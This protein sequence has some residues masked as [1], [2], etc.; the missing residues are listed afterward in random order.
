MVKTK[1]LSSAIHAFWER[2]GRQRII[3]TYLMPL[4]F[5]CAMLVT[6]TADAQI[7]VDGNPA[8]WPAGVYSNPA[9]V[10]KTFVADLYNTAGDDV[11]TGGGSKDISPISL[12][13]WELQAANDKTDI[14][15]AG[16]A[17][18]GNKL[19]FFGDHYSN[20]G[21]ASIGLWILK[22]EVNK[23]P[24]V[25]GLGS[26][27]GSHAD[28]DLLITADLPGG[29]RHVYKWLTG[30]LVEVTL[31]TAAANVV[32]NS[33]LYPAPWPFTP[34]SGAVNTY[35]TSSFFEGFV[36]LDSLGVSVDFCFT[37]FFLSTRTSQSTSA[38]L[39]DLCRGQFATRPVVTVTNDTVCAGTAAEF[40]ASTTG[41]LPPITY[42]WNSAPYAADS[43]YTINPATVDTFVT[44]VAQGSNG[45]LS[46]PDTAYL[47]IKPTATVDTI[48]NFVYCNGAAGSAVTF[49][50]TPGGAT[51]SWS[52]SANVGFGTS[53]T[54]SIG[55]YTATNGGTTPVVA[56]VS[57][58]ATRNSC[59][60]PTRTFMVTVN[61]TPTLNTVSSFAV[62]RGALA[63]AVHFVGG[64][65]GVTNFSWTSSIDI[66][67]GLSGADSIGAFTAINGGLVAL[68]TTVTVT[69]SAA[70][71]PGAPVQFAVTV[72]PSAAVN[73]HGDS[74]YCNGASAGAL[75]FTS[76]VAGTTFTWTASANVGFGASGSG[77]IPGYTATNTTTATIVSTVIVTP[78]AAGCPGVA[79]TFLITVNPT[80]TVG[81]HGEATY[82]N[83]DSASAITFTGGVAGTTFTWTSTINVGFGNAGT[84]NIPAYIA[85]NIGTVKL[86]TSVV[87][88]P[89]A[90]GCTGT[91]DT[92]LV[93]ALPTP[94][95]FAHGDSTYC[96]G[97]SAGAIV[98]AGGGIP[99]ATTFNW[100]SSA[101]VGFGTS[102]VG[103][104]PAYT[105]LNAGLV[106]IVAT[107]I[108]TPTGAG[109]TGV[110][111]TFLITVNPT[112]TVGA[113]GEATYCNGDS[114]SAIAFTGGVAG[115]TF[116]WTSTINVGFGNAGT[117]DIP[118]YIATNIGT[119]KLVTSVV[120][121]PSANGCT[122]TPD[123][124]L[125]TALPT[126][127]VFAHGDST[128]CNGASAGAIVFAGGGIPGATT[129]NW[130]SSANVGFGTSG[131]GDIPAYTALNAGLVPIVATVI[132]TPT[133]AG[134]TGVADTFL[135]TV[136][137]NPSIDPVS[138]RVHCNGDAATG[139]TFSGVPPGI[140]FT[141]VSSI[142][143]G[144]GTSGSGSIGA[145]TATNTGTTPVV[146][147]VTVTPSASSC[148]GGTATF[149]VTVNPT[150]NVA[151]HGDS[152]Y[153]N[154]AS[155][156]ALNFTGGVAGTAF[157]WSGTIDV[158][159]GTAGTGN[160]P[161]YIAT[162]VG[163]VKLI[164]S[165]VVTPSAAGCTGIA[166]TFTVTVL[167][168][169]T[170][171]AHG[172][173]TY[174]NGA[175][176]GAIIFAGGGIPGATT[177][178][179]TSSVN[180]GFGTSGT[181][182]IS[183]YTA[184]NAGLV[185]VV[186]T[187][188]VT[189]TGAGC[190]GVADTFLITVNPT[191]N[192][193]AHGDS[194]YCA[195]A[196]APGLNFTG[197]IGG[198]TFT[199]T[200][201]AN[202]GFGIAGSGNIPAYTALNAGL[203]P[204]VATVIVTPTANG[205]AGTPDTFL[206]TVNPNPS[207]DPVSSRVHCNGD[208]ATGITFSGVPPG[209]TFTWVSSINVG[210]GTSGSGSI[211]AYTAT[212][213][214]TTPVVATV[215]VTPSVTSCGGGVITFMVT[216]NPTPNVA[217]HGDSTYCN[218]ASAGALNFTGG[219]AGTAFTWSGTIDVGFGTAGTG[220]IPA[221]IA[222][223]IGTVKLITSVVVTPSAAGCT[224][225]AD[226]FT[227]TVLPTPT[228]F[229][230]GDST[231]CNGA[232][233]G[234]IIF[235]GGGIPGATT[236][237]WTSSV[238]V[239]FG[240]SGT[241]DISAYTA[242]NA[243][244]VPVVA[245]VIVTPTGAGCTGVADTFLITVNPTPTVAAHGD[246]TYCSSALA[247]GLN[248]TGGIAGTTFTWTSTANVGFGI[249][250]SGNIP[251]YTALNAGLVP[252]VATVIVTP[253]A[254]GC[255]GTPDTFLI[256]VNPNPSIDP[257]SNRVHCNGDAATG[258]TFSG[259]PPGITFTWVS[260]INVGFG[261]SG[262]GS[263]GAYTATNTGTTPVVAT[264]SVT[265]SVTSCGGGVI[266][267]MVTVNP[268]PN[269]AAHGD[270]T[271]CKGILAPGLNFTGAVAGTTFSWT[272]SANVGFGT[273]GAGNIPA[274]TTLNP[275]STN[276]VATVIVTPSKYGCTGAKDTFLITIRPRPTVPY[277]GNVTL[278]SKAPGGPINI[279]GGDVV[280]TYTWIGT[281]NVGFGTSGTGNIGAFTA[282]NNP[283]PGNI[284]DTV[285][286]SVTS[287]AGCPGD[288]RKFT[289]TILPK[290]VVVAR[291]TTLCAGN[292]LNLIPMGTPAGGTWSGPGVS[293]TTFTMGTPGTYKIYYN[294]SNG[295]GCSGY[296]SAYICVTECCVVYG[297]YT[298]GIW[299][300]CNITLCDGKT[301][302]SGRKTPVQL[303]NYLLSS[304]QIT[305]G[306]AGRSVIIPTYAAA[307]V[308]AV[309]PGSY[310]PSKLTYA[311]NV[312]IS[313]AA[314]SIF[315]VNYLSGGKLKNSL[316]GEQ[317]AMKLNVRMTPGLVN[318]PIVYTAGGDSYFQT[319]QAN[320]VCCKFTCGNTCPLCFCIKKSVAK[321]LTKG[322]T[323]AAN[324]NSLVNLADDLLGGV[325]TPGAT[326]GGYVVPSYADV[327][328]A[329]G[330]VSSAFNYFRT[331]NGAYGCSAAKGAIASGN[332]TQDPI[333]IESMTRI[334]PN[335]TTGVFT[336]EVPALEKD[337]HVTVLD[338]NGRSVMSATVSA[339]PYE[340]KVQLDMPDVSRGM[341]FIRIETNGKI[342]AKKLMLE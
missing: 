285:T 283:G 254:N 243:G 182:D 147:T 258:I 23:L 266:T 14:E 35:P 116:T 340:Q 62:C 89:S 288:T 171:F 175:S 115:T 226:T 33:T 177:F 80:P 12:W 111:D 81:A 32:V 303:I 253:T 336:I 56:T 43:T 21:S 17:L 91:P 313:N 102:G 47:V 265:P 103:D 3:R 271:Y 25:A 144:F 142:N 232:S 196:L 37:E 268:T 325:L 94:T 202:V 318:F 264:V 238:N 20:A 69:P 293:G 82:C 90:N 220:N 338:M 74:V 185:P 122:G 222:T 78:S 284:V 57:V 106:P 154:G 305:V 128:Y 183:A 170:V 295:S 9:V 308:N 163:T 186:A 261:T 6:R 280:N 104:I 112:P 256:T 291:D 98:F 230:H 127:T 42:S 282:I 164:T 67:F 152:T 131:V 300:S 165:V 187:V 321:Y 145:Y 55:T 339:N 190:T 292:S 217:V 200:S 39:E 247:P 193:A 31:S 79:D 132:V 249:A 205:C 141:W 198:T 180:V 234:A 64:L 204:V 269:V 63:N 1:L 211:G 150:P 77:N 298:Q 324:L 302:C 11:F 30:G 113:H 84:G 209:I 126:P 4:L 92:F 93:T 223:N 192:V 38:V 248:F 29:N 166:D 146:A 194:T 172:D 139:I 119:V 276:F 15:N 73:P 18:I 179:W 335:P 262:S 176:A 71:C 224:G 105:A 326:V 129:F 121:T 46:E 257:V 294:V 299:S 235:A 41:G 240:T 337:A 328:A 68:V 203:V 242:L 286:V 153:C 135:I 101:N 159:F 120:V 255:A 134:C 130:T 304:G 51:F 26:F 310:G 168:T 206:I 151:V 83:G 316:L 58:T 245:T 236:F 61:P 7:T 123:T 333:T 342:F 229:A 49:T 97:A 241:G 244:L 155:A 174:C 114:A 22:N 137:P 169:P 162:N 54:G 161:A 148:G 312:T 10:F 5:I 76:G 107:V 8:D 216:V 88:T 251:A 311:G 317:I 277:I 16:M 210:F 207:I 45:C 309:M 199:W 158:G 314:G 279:T 281:T 341:Y 296:D 278:C 320:E 191:P 252:V 173:S 60:G 133:G 48:P 59:V 221:Y 100:T 157:T 13:K 195:S 124:F 214:G 270:S 275:G 237:N 34:K 19:Y 143:V 201:T 178:N 110:A 53:G 2:A 96:N 184:L 108:V 301:N 334:Y 156:G 138:S 322:G 140:T 246:S 327:A 213:T 86:V 36:D 239:G 267:F 109:C 208:A 87:V 259:V 225:I 197:G 66:G 149:M 290:P 50:S 219:V 323:Q 160:I 189:P 99:G 85:T 297:A 272:S 70:G 72:N 274:Y 24:L 136:N 28:G 307:T 65:P 181:G 273:S 215:S 260:S 212:N 250:G 331:F 75:N 332:T 44:V 40:L 306:R 27:S 218:G 228:V 125:V 118:A 319:F 95:V 227:V 289:V 315:A 231:Y 117:G 188:I 52:S 287:T 330:S 329:L 233:A 167:P 263:I